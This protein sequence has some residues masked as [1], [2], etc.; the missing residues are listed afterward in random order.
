MRAAA[1][2]QEVPALQTCLR[3]VMTRDVVCVGPDESAEDALRLLVEHGISGLPVVDAAG[4]PLGVLSRADLLEERLEALTE[5]ELGEPA[6]VRD[7]MTQAALSLPESASVAEAAGLM[8]AYGVHRV[9]VVS[10]AGVL[11]GVVSPLDLLR[12]LTGTPQQA[13]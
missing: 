4:R 8:A 10:A 13:S 5:G 11:V 6:R 12:W 9:Q 2:S 1:L 7:L 3:E